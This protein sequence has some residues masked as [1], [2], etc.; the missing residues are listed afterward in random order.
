MKKYCYSWQR[1]KADPLKMDRYRQWRK[2]YLLKKRPARR[3]LDSLF[4]AT[5]KGVVY[6]RVEELFAAELSDKEILRLWK[7]IKHWLESTGSRE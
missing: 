1:L 6:K 4:P 2:K 5:S 3:T 7:I